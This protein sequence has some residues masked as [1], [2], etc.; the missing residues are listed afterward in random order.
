[1]KK[2]NSKKPKVRSDGKV[3]V[4]LDELAEFVIRT[5]YQMSNDIED[6]KRVVAQDP[7]FVTKVGQELAVSLQSVSPAGIQCSDK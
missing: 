5:L 1:M 6:I 7:A 2:R 3:A 4:S